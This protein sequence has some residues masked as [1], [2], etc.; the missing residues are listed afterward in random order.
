MS[1]PKKAKLSALIKRKE[2][3]ASEEK[4]ATGK[5]PNVKRK[6]KGFLM[7]IEHSRRYNMLRERL[8][9]DGPDMAEEMVD[10]FLIYH[11]EEPVVPRD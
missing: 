10:R 2:E 6:V 11:G 1:D 9:A 7:S 3:K 4:P 5:V 8:A